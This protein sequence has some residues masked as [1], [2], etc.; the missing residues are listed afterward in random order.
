MSHLDNARMALHRLTDIPYL[1][2]E[3]T[4]V[5]DARLHVEEAKAHAAI[6]QAVALERIADRLDSWT[7]DPA[8]EPEV[9]GLGEITDLNNV[10]PEL[11]VR[12]W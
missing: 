8:R 10:G 5:Q 3:L 7:H 6:A 9:P 4:K 12:R 2:D 1:G 11:R